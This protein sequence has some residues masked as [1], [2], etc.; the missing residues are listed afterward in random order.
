MVAFM[1]IF[2]LVPVYYLEKLDFFRSYIRID[3]LKYFKVVAGI[4]PYGGSLIDHIDLS[5]LKL[6]F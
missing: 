2:R 5:P 6:F 1:L 4:P 3:P